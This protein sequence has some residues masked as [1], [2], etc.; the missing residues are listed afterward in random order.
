M[1]KLSIVSALV[2]NNRCFY[3][4]DSWD[5]NG[6]VIDRYILRRYLATKLLSHGS[7]LGDCF[8]VGRIDMDLISVTW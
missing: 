4:H 2:S 8:F 1:F 3:Q 7:M 5:E 6:Y